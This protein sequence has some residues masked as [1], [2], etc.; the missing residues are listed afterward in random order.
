MTKKQIIIIT[1]VIIFTN[2]NLS[3]TELEGCSDN[4]YKL[5]IEEDMKKY[6]VD[7][8]EKSILHVANVIGPSC[9]EIINKQFQQGSSY[10]WGFHYLNKFKRNLIYLREMKNGDDW[11]YGWYFENGKYFQYIEGRKISILIKLSEKEKLDIQK[12][13]LL[14]NFLTIFSGHINFRTMSL[15]ENSNIEVTL[16]GADFVE[17]Y[18]SKT[19]KLEKHKRDYF[20]TNGEYVVFEITKIQYPVRNIKGRTAYAPK[21]II[22]GLSY[23]DKRSFKGYS[24]DDTIDWEQEMLKEFPWIPDSLEAFKKD[25]TLYGRTPTYILDDPGHRKFQNEKK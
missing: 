16:K 1:S 14:E 8:P 19:F 3:S 5:K 4:P 22:Y 15:T 11:L 2:I 18:F 24:G 20:W 12:D 13:D 23:N 17:G 9:E 25:T 21:S 7:A 10:E 6:I